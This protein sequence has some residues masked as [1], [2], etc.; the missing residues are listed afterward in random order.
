M[1]G[2]LLDRIFI[3][4]LTVP[5]I[6]PL[7]LSNFPLTRSSRLKEEGFIKDGPSP[8]FFDRRSPF[9]TF[10]NLKSGFEK[11]LEFSIMFALGLFWSL[12]CLA[13]KTTAHVLK[14]VKV[15]YTSHIASDIHKFRKKLSTLEA[16]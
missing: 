12:W 2:F 16:G 6:K 4:F 3:D 13:K 5:T 11:F 9:S 1:V 14:R 7:E 15:I 10:N 8:G